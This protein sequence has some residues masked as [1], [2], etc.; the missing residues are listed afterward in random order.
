MELFKE[1]DE[2]RRELYKMGF[3]NQNTQKFFDTFMPLLEN[4]GIYEE[5]N[6]EICFARD[7]EKNHWTGQ[8]K[9]YL[10]SSEDVASVLYYDLHSS[11]LTHILLDEKFYHSFNDIE[12]QF[13]QRLIT[14]VNVF[15]EKLGLNRYYN[16][17]G[18][19][20][21]SN[22]FYDGSNMKEAIVKL[23]RD[24]FGDYDFLL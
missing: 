16:L 8:K 12:D 24:Y 5:K 6:F 7:G 17:D 14:G 19:N 22:F 20:I 10:D 1:F 13:S 2:Y 15:Y 21:N 3:Y 18:K 23:T 9:T 4:G 11:Y